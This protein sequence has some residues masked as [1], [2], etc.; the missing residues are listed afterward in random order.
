[1]PARVSSF[2]RDPEVYAY[3]AEKILPKLID[4]HPDDLPIR[5]WIA[6]CSSGLEAYSLTI[7]F[8]EAIARSKRDIPVQVFASDV[9]A[10]VIQIARQG[11]YPESIATQISP[12]RLKRYFVKEED[13]YRIK[14]ELRDAVVFTA[15]DIL[16]DPP[17][18]RLD[19]ISC[20]NL[21]I[22]LGAQAQTK[23]ISLF[24]FALRDGGILLLGN[25]ETVGIPENR[26]E[27]I[28]KSA[29]LYRR[30]GRTRPDDIGWVLTTDGAQVRSSSEEL[31][32]LNQEL[33]SLNSQL[34]ETL[35]RQRT[36]SD[37]L[38]N[39]LFSTDVATL[40]LDMDL[41]HR[42]GCK[43]SW[44]VAFNSGSSFY[45]VSGVI[46]GTSR[47]SWFT[48]ERFEPCL[49]SGGSKGSWNGCD[50]SSQGRDL[51]PIW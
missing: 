27:V 32:S 5:V 41:I 15:Q 7:L 1:M 50:A 45:I 22:H 10:E 44:A 31:Q 49:S 28:S 13:G 2:F 38:K 29:R 21:L 33:R 20:R 39:V 34:Q 23:I 36:A 17:F 9:D 30:I 51:S 11:D 47:S 37:D 3:L 42:A 46:Y 35:E 48:R 19:F 14:A 6:G 4:N 12:E 16:R 25:T 8:R 24:H 40:F 18:S 26:F 43:S